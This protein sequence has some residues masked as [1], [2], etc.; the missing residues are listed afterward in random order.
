MNLKYGIIHFAI[1]FF[2]EKKNARKM[3]IHRNDLYANG[4][5][6]KQNKENKTEIIPRLHTKYANEKKK[7]N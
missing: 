1:I 2:Y 5:D 6:F 4:I 7:L 3:K